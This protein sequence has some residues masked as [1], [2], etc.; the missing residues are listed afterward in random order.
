MQPLAGQLQNIISDHYSQ[1]KKISEEEYIRKPAPNKWSKKEILGHLAD[2]AQ[3]NIR[4]FIV[5]QYEEQ[6]FIVYNQDQWVAI[7]NYQQYKT[8]DLIE[9]WALLNKHICIILSNTSDASALRTCATNNMQLHTIQWLAEDYI[10]HL[11]HHLHQ[12]LDMEPVAYP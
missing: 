1:L 4:R 10:K 9:L 8:S 2:S 7:S 3:N 12:V 11:R 5:T 6:P